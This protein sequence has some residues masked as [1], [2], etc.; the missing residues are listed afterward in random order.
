MM[1]AKDQIKKAR[2]GL[3]LDQPF[4]GSLA[5]RLEVVED[6]TCETAWTDGKRLGFNPEFVEN[7]NLDQIKGLLAHEVMHCA[8]AHQARRQGREHDK[9]NMAGDYAINPL[10]QDSGFTLPGEPLIDPAY[11]GKSADE[12]YGL[13]PKP[14]PDQDQGQDQ[15]QGQGDQ[16]QGQGQGQGQDQGQQGQGGGD[17]GGCG[18]VRDAL[19]PDGQQP[20][21]ADL[22]QQAQ[23]WKVAATQA[24]QQAK[25]M[26][27]LP[28]GMERWVQEL[29]DPKVDWREILR[30]FIDMNARNDYAWTP[31]NRR[32]VH[33]GL[34]LPSLRSEELAA[35]V[36]AIDTSGSIS[37]DELDQF[38]SELSEIL[39]H[40]DTNI[41]VLYCD[42]H[43]AGHEA[44][45]Q[46]D[47]PLELHPK[48]GGG[49]DFRPPFGWVD[50]QGIDP[51]CF[52]YLTDLQCN[53]YPDAPG[54]P[55]L[56][57]AT[58]KG[59]QPPFGE[60]VYM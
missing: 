10:L 50:Q 47:I 36:V 20:S 8:C 45:T 41:D 58:D 46:Q 59:K 17:P 55:V 21:Q 24:A 11:S 25:A 53:R 7:L 14:E 33:M 51:A 44:F 52:V 57:V 12:I 16:G 48:G 5:L 2:A 27:N 13:L 56:W 18:E 40:Y 37:A 1:M 6:L 9:W 42:A 15:G 3:I 4:F 26:G 35:I 43:L 32:F 31:P 19:G 49:T 22:N 60:V 54:Y 28:A 30:R 29:I 38:A 39:E 23:D 34:Y